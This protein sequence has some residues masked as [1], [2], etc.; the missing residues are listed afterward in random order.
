MNIHMAEEKWEALEVVGE[1]VREAIKSQGTNHIGLLGY[2]TD[3]GF[4]SDF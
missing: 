4:H 2:F 1:E 3:V